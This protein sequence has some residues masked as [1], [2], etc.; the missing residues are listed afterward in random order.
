[1]HRTLTRAAVAAVFA[2]S[3][4]AQ[5]ASGV[6]ALPQAKLAQL[7]AQQ[8]ARVTTA[9]REM[10]GLRSQLGLGAQA[11]FVSH[12]AFTNEQGRAVV[13]FSQT[14]QGYRVWA[15]EAIVHV[16]ADGQLRS[17][18]QDVQSG[19]TLEGSPRLTAAEARDIALRNLAPKGPMKLA[20]K[21]ERVVFPSRYTGGLA[22]RFDEAKGREVVDHELSTW[23]KA[24]AA[25]YVWAY[26]VKTHLMNR[27]DGLK[28]YSYIIDGNSGA[29]LRKWNELKSDS[30]A[31]GTGN[32][33]YSGTVSLATTKS[34]VDGSHSLVAMDRGSLVNPFL[35]SYFGTT[36]TGLMSMYDAFT[37][38]WGDAAWSVYGGNQANV[39]GDGQ[40]FGGWDFCLNADETVTYLCGAPDTN[41]ETAGV[42]THHGLT[43]SWDFYKNIFE[44]EGIDGVG[45][46]TFGL[47]HTPISDWFGNVSRMNDA[48]WAPWLF[49]LVLGDGNAPNRPDD[50][51]SL[52]EMDIIGHEFTHGVTESSAGLIYSGESGGLNEAT[53]DILGKMVQAYGKRAA[54]EDT[55]IPDFASGDLAAWELGRGSGP[56]GKP[57]RWMYKPSL[58]GLSPDAWYDGIE[59]VNVHFSSGPLN[60]AFYFLAQGAAQNEPTSPTYSEFLPEGMTGIG[61]DRAARIWYKALP[62]YLSLRSTY[63]DAREAALQSAQ[64]LFGAG[65]LEE[66]AVM[67]AFAAVNVGTLPGQQPA[68]LVRFPV[69]HPEGHPLGGN[70]T[71]I[72]GILG[73]V[74]LFPTRTP[75]VVKTV[76][77][78]TDNKAVTWSLGGPRDGW[79]G[80]VINADGTWTTPMWTYGSE[81]LTLTAT[82]QADPR[83]FAK[84]RVLVIELDAD[85]D[86]ETDALDVGAIAMAWGLQGVPHES[87]RPAGYAP[88]DWSLVYITE[89]IQNAWPVK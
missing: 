62:E 35:S 46:S 22:S 87:L 68:I 49:G 82:S 50:F 53:S 42:D 73:K 14:H 26:E 19:I 15:G 70:N 57:I 20:P 64:A 69:V 84:G 66:Q 54:G 51:G 80:G 55:T 21:V 58:D 29:I 33:L 39:W 74:Q 77:E 48:Y 10:L 32:S 63:A 56:N 25:P 7:K 83:R 44:R 5:A 88:P 40:A 75:V 28:E 85:R 27:Q 71:S 12:N 8:S 6:P 13:R 36:Q 1:M 24:P 67:K 31:V 11:G 76:V 61:N 17:L 78:N 45:T 37:V 59:V 3:L 43:T 65:S 9:Q 2:L 23:S 4:A 34:D 47:N 86:T 18:T 81:F 52:T 72:P 30:P 16:E 79:S 38:P 60:R 41:G 89:A